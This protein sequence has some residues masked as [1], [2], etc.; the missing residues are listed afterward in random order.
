[1]LL[2][3]DP[4]LSGEAL[5]VLRDMGHGDSIALVDANFPAHFLG[6]AVIRMD[7][8]LARAGRAIL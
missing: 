8:D 1:M 7:N 3:I 6:P 4:L 2:G 5:A